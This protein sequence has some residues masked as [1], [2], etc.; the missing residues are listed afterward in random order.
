MKKLF[1]SLVLALCFL[2]LPSFAQNTWISG[3]VTDTSGAPVVGVTVTV[4]GSTRG[5]TTDTDGNYRIQGAANDVLL[6]QCLGYNPQE[7]KIG[8]KTAINIEL[9]ESVENLEDVVVTGYQTISKERA[10]GSFD[11]LNKA[12]LEKPSSNIASRLIGS[13]AGL[14]STQ[15]AYGNPVFEIRGRS[16]LTTSATQPLLVVDGFAIEGGFE[17]INPNDVESISILKDAAAAS[18]WGAKSANGVIVV[19]TKNAKP[20]GGGSGASVTVDYSGFLKVSPKLDLDYTL[21]QASV[22]DIIDYEVYGF[23]HMDSSIWYHEENDYS[24]GMSR[25]YELLTQNR[26]GHLSDADM[27]AQINQLRNYSNHDQIKKYLLQN[28]IVHQE[29]VAVNIATER[30][31]NTLSAMYQNNRQHYKKYNANQYMINF[32]NRTHLFK[33]LDFNFNGSYT[34]SKNDNSGT[35]LPDLSPYEMLVDESGKLIR[36]SNSIDLNYVDRHVPKEEFPYDDWS[37]N[38]IEEMNNRELI[39]TKTNARVQAGLTVKIWQGLTFDSRIQYEMIDSYTHNYYNE[40]TYL[41]RS[42]V[43]SASSWD[44]ETNE[45]TPNLPTGGFLDQSRYRYDVLTVR[46]QLNFNHTFAEKHAIAFVAGIETIDRVYQYFGYPRTYGYNDETLSVGNFPNGIGGTG[47]YQLTNWQGSNQTFGYQNSFSYTTDRYF[48]AFGN[49]SYTFDDRYTVSGSIRTDASNLITDDPQYRYAPF[50]SVGASWHIGRE[51]F[52]QNVA[53]VDAL[54]L[55][56]TYGYNGNVD[57]TTTFKPLVNITT[58]PNV[59][60]GEYTGSMS[61]YGNPTLRW[62][63]TGTWNIGVDFSLLHGK[64]FGKFDVYNKHSEDLIADV[65]LPS[66]QGTSTMKLNNGE[67]LNRGFEMEVGSTL[68]I[69]RHISWTGSL[70]LSYNKNRITSLAV[71][72]TSAYTL[73]MSNGDSSGWMEGYDM[74]TLWCYKYGGLQN[75]GSATSPVMKPTLVTK[76]GEYK[77]FDSWPAG[78][79][80]DHA[81]AMGTL[82][83]PW[84]MAISSSFRVYDFDI[85]FIIT[86]KFGHKFMRES[87]NYPGMTGRSIP[88]S[89]YSEVVNGDPNEIIPLPQT[90]TETR[91]YFWD[92]FFP[93]MSYLAE[94]ASHLRLQEFNVT[95]NV[96]QKAVRKIGLRSLQVYAQCN[97]PFNVYFNKYNEDP[98]FPRGSIRLQASYTFGI[99]CK[100]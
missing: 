20:E 7:M 61:S 46:N 34:Y 72:P 52:M 97:N 43:N 39:T 9:Q 58:S 64:L 65:S 69:T 55:R 35:G 96:P 71:E 16:S 77:T 48:S 98:E 1:A 8:Q 19:T 75:V 57:K 59:V 81:Y 62:E 51:K 79:P 38:P 28:P 42:T 66:V 49:L 10:T 32:R 17:S 45:V 74:N 68:P 85:S 91:Y 60:T 53:W 84:N 5:T 67:L 95:Y 37:W 25:I 41:V 40:N 6:F 12:Q 13:V 21:S 87:F 47:V 93:Y 54:S 33:W 90:D 70:T 22:N 36:Y 82:V 14:T 15:D 88:N 73:A 56:A 92:R 18:I 29:N 63:R 26:L 23:S 78:D 76:G 80:L 27:N 2:A 4:K 99:K 24:G 30:S 83:A 50:W 31:S 94:S 89:K 86:G 100:F 3:Q 44:K 11:I